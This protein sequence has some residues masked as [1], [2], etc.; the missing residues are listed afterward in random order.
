MKCGRIELLIIII[1]YNSVMSLGPPNASRRLAAVRTEFAGI[2]STSSKSTT[3]A[4]SASK[5]V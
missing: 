4:Q 2:D 1:I 3:V 5:L